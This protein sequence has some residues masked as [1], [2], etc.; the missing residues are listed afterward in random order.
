MKKRI[1]YI[2]L[3]AAL[4]VAAL[5]VSAE[6]IKSGAGNINIIEIA[7]GFDYDI[8]YPF[9]SGLAVVVKDDKYGYVDKMGK[10][11]IPCVY[12]WDYYVQHIE[13]INGIFIIDNL[14]RVYKDGKWG[15]IDKTGKE[16]SPCIYEK[17]GNFTEGLAVAITAETGK[18][19]KYGY[20]DKTGKEVIPCIYDEAHDFSDGLG[21]VRKGQWG[22]IDKTGRE[23]LPFKYSSYP[24]SDGLAQVYTYEYP[25]KTG[26]NGYMN[27]TGEEVI[28]PKYYNA[29]PFSEGFAAVEIGYW[30]Y[31]DKTGNEITPYIYRIAYP[32]KD[33]LASVM[34]KD[35]WGL[36]D[37]TGEEIIPCEYSAAKYYGN[38]LFCVRKGGTTG[39]IDKN[40]KEVVPFGV[41]SGIDAPYDEFCNMSLVTSAETGKYGYIDKTGKEI[42]PCIYD[43]ADGFSE[44][45]S[46]VKTGNKWGYIDET[47][48]E[49]VPL[50]YD[51]ADDFSEGF[52]CVQKGGKM[53]YVDKMGKEAVP[54]IYDSD[55][56]YWRHKFSEGFAWIK[57]D[58][59]FVL[60][61][62]MRVGDVLGDVKYTDI[63]AFINGHAIPS[64]NIN[65]Y[66]YICVE[67]LMRYGFAV[68][69]DYNAKMLNVEWKNKKFE[70][71]KVKKETGLT[72]TFKCNY[73][74]T[75]IKTYLSGTEVPS[76][77]IN[78]ET[79]IHFDLLEQYG[80]VV[81]DGKARTISLLL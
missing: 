44:G 52:G 77:N 71:I 6:P 10:E 48:K 2:L 26:L 17:V 46:R 32:F 38:G 25:A 50:I 57:K 29:A 21:H 36:I 42:I 8:V 55:D 74:Y 61:Q 13:N 60:L 56:D 14:I 11:V 23:I 64:H 43:F 28:P 62:I 7:S 16:I 18:W 24:F 20:V 22:Y 80:T 30:A 4:V 54:L 78:G 49:A 67:D 34:R 68:D 59:K 5:N 31:I 76:Y 81:W 33:G 70:P 58:G 15:F 72:G 3:L 75:N 19:G 63:V 69:W 12:D 41:Y 66:T 47:G 39:L 79:L 40:N 53:G 51:S 1:I 35:K 45:L 9:N 37:T 65:G 73:Y 27:K